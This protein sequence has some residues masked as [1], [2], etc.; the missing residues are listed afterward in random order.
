MA[1]KRNRV[2]YARRDKKRMVPLPAF[3]PEVRGGSPWHMSE[4][5]SNTAGTHNYLGISASQVLPTGDDPDS[6]FTRLHELLHAAHS[7]LEGPRDVVYKGTHIEA[8]HIEMAEEFRLNTYSR[9]MVGYKQLPDSTPQREYAKV[10]VTQAQQI[11]NGDNIMQLIHWDM[12]TWALDNSNQMTDETG[13]VFAAI[14]TLL[15]DAYQNNDTAT[16]HDLEQIRAVIL[17]V[18]RTIIGDVFY[19]GL[20][21]IF[22]K[23]EMP[24]WEE[25]MEIAK[26]LQEYREALR[27]ALDNDPTT[28]GAAGEGS[29]SGESESVPEWAQ[30]P[31]VEEFVKRVAGGFGRSQEKKSIMQ[32]VRRERNRKT[33]S[34]AHSYNPD[35]IRWGDMDIRKAK[36]SWKLPKKFVSKS[37]YRGS[38]EGAVPRYVHRMATDGRI[39]GRKKK[40]PGGSV[41]IDDS[42]SMS[43]SMDE[44]KGI[45]QAAPASVIA[46][47]SGTGSR[48]ELVILAEDGQCA[49]VNIGANLPYGGNNT[50]DYPALQW[51][52]E[53]ER[54]RIWVSDGHVVPVYGEYEDAAL[55]CFE[56]C[57]MNGIN[58]VFTAE[59]AQEA[60]E[61]KRALYR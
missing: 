19:D 49:D 8:Q 37:K 1:T 28:Q 39:F 16:M 6:R 11:P 46:A 48:G 17:D 42:G 53:Q 2:R 36:K 56:F 13:C 60:F 47:Y 23:G 26:F 61:G 38:D 30:D 40:T 44:L 45:I 15:G 31:D 18:H 4:S 20:M 5:K 33:S 57:A 25:T 43:W 50:V 7:P 10:L 34:D 24:T 32:R 14:H 3:L 35:N 22:Q 52:A 27:N 59:E 41:L 9:M 29:G 51:L 21:K 55:Q 58:M 12:V 54:P